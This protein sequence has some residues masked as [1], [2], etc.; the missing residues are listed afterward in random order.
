MEPGVAFGFLAIL[1]IASIIIAVFYLL[2]L[3]NA[4]KQVSPGNRTIPPENVWLMFIPLFNIIYGFIM[5]PKISESL[6]AEFES[7]GNP[8]QG[9]YLKG[10]GIAM[11]ILSIVGII[12][13]IGT[14]TG[15]ANL[16][17][18]IVY[19]VKIAE[20]TNK[21]K[22]TPSGAVAGSSDDLLDA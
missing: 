17:I 10:L 20:F 7:R 2:A 11:P 16:I 18:F 6:K 19:W 21:L 14:L 5:Y 13:Y 9:D 15:I 22:S 8:Q 3:Q 4:L 12:P 1:L